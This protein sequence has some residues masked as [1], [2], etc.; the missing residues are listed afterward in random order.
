ME[1]PYKVIWVEEAQKNLREIA[2]P[3]KTNLS[4]ASKISKTKN[5]FKCYVINRSQIEKNSY[6]SF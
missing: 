1:R 5:G 3:Y 4:Y 2:G 6:Q